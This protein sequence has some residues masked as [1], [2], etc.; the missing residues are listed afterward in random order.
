MIVLF[1][2]IQIVL[3]INTNQISIVNDTNEIRISGEGSIK[4]KDFDEYKNEEKKVIIED[5]ITCIGRAAF[6]EAKLKEI[7][8][9]K[10]VE[11][12]EKRAFENCQTLESVTFNSNSNLTIID[13]YA[14]R[15]CINLK[16]IQLPK[17]LKKKM[18][19]IKLKMILFI[20]KMKVE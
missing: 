6:A 18:N 3:S 12:I 17:S 1:L 7:E 20:P 9:G 15:N 14:F 2:L 16:S 4:Q 11:S 19:I 8:I 13:D 5:A 10:D